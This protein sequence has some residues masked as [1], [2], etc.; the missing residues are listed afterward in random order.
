MGGR[1][2]PGRRRFALVSRALGTQQVIGGCRRPRAQ[3]RSWS[4]AR[5]AQHGMGESRWGEDGVQPIHSPSAERR[6][7]PRGRAAWPSRRALGTRGTRAPCGTAGGVGVAGRPTGKGRASSLGR[8][9]ACASTA[10]E[11]GIKRLGSTPP[12]L[13]SPRLAPGRIRST[14]TSILKTPRNLAHRLRCDFEGSPSPC[15]SCAT[16]CAIA[17][18]WPSRRVTGALLSST[19]LDVGAWTLHPRHAPTCLA[20]ESGAA[21]LLPPSAD[22]CA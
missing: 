1:G 12:V 9:S 5:S 8:R 16:S 7:E 22:V 4:A 15:P 18:A 14:S 21:G 20:L 17:P 3:C 11:G 13:P 10:G 2:E 6:A 19:A